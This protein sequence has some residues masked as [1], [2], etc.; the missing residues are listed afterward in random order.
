MEFKI[1]FQKLGLAVKDAKLYLTA[2]THRSYLNESKQKVESNERLEFLGDAILS[3]I[4][5]SFLFDSRINDAEG[6]LTHLRAFI[7]KT[8]SL[9]KAAINLNLGRFLRM[10]KGE[11]I[12]KGRENPQLLANTYEATL[13][14]VYLDLGLQAAT[15]FVHSTLLPM[16]EKEIK[17]GAPKDAKSTLQEISQSKF[18]TSPKYKIL[19]TLGPD[20]AKQFKVG[21]FIGDKL[22]GRGEGNSKQ[23]AEEEAA[24][25]ALSK[26]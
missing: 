18:Q 16:F 17:S 25:E 6:E 5:S 15:Q 7:V 11:E 8:D 21:V 26:I 13:G 22:Q 12:S 23:Q 20:H 19:G 2:F 3:L 24:K 14:A 9:A 1:I 10:S 4:I